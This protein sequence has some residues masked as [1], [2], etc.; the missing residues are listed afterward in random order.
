MNDEQVTMNDTR[1]TEPI[2]SLNS[3]LIGHGGSI[4]PTDFPEVAHFEVVVEMP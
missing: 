1:V 4:N 3:R 2:L